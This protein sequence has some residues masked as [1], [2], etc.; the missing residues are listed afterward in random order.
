MQALLWKAGCDCAVTSRGY[1]KL[2]GI[3]GVISIVMSL[4]ERDVYLLMKPVI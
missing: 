4:G 1:D 2:D 3:D